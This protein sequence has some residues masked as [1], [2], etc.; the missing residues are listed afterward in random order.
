MNL[1][2]NFVLGKELCTVPD[3]IL[4][5]L[6]EQLV[7]HNNF[8]T[9]DMNQP[10]YRQWDLHVDGTKGERLPDQI[11]WKNDQYTI[12]DEFFS[13]YVKHIFR[14]RLSILDAHAEIK[15]HQ[16]HRYPRIHIP[17]NDTKSTFNVKN[18]LGT[19]QE[20]I[21]MQYGKAYMINVALPHSVDP[22]INIR[23]NAF[24][25]FDEFT[26]KELTNKF[27]AT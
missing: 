4:E 3:G 16:A 21:T 1:A 5:F 10:Q 2:H 22:V 27:T 15:W 26:T 17:L 25:C 18:F 9:P 11:V 23:H 20:T 6:K 12:I 13:E 19:K 14:F 7:Y 24:F 8:I